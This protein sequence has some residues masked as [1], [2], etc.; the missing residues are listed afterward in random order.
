RSYQWL[1][2][3]PA[4]LVWVEALDGGNP[5]EKVPHRDKI[6]SLAAP[7]SGQPHQILQTEER[8]RGLTALA[9][10]KALVQDY[11]RVQRIER[12]MGID[13]EKPGAPVQIIFRRNERD[14]Y[15]APGGAGDPNLARRP[16]RASAT[17]RRYLSLRAWRFA[18]RRPALFGPLQSFY[19]QG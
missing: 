17:G 3:K 12:T 10:G 8:F 5:K 13:L 11:E 4:T 9:G 18:V 7:F 2:D 6:V 1:P 14:A 19:R 16:A 15:H